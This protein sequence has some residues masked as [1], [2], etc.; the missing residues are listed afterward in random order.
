MAQPLDVE[1]DGLAL[2]TYGF[3]GEDEAAL[4]GLGLNT[5]GFLWPVNGIWTSCICVDESVETTWTECDC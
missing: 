2:L 4:E 3:V 5:F 1:I